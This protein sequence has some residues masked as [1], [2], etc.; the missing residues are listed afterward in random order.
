MSSRRTIHHMGV[1]TT[2]DDNRDP[3]APPSCT[4]RRHRALMSDRASRHRARHCDRRTR[5]AAHH[6]DR[7]GAYATKPP[8][9]AAWRHCQRAQQALT[10]ALPCT[11]RMRALTQAHTLVTRS[12]R[13]ASRS[14]PIDRPES[15]QSYS[16]IDLRS[17]RC[18]RGSGATHRSAPLPQTVRPPQ[19]SGEGRS[20]R[21]AIACASTRAAYLDPHIAVSALRRR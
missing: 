5:H 21:R 10:A 17:G 18:E 19:R 11:S 1:S 15:C 8:G 14:A 7:T 3:T 2:P 13:C 12:E 16:P 4:V 6:Y 9:P 20:T